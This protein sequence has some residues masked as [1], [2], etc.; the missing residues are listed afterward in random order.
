MK[1][2]KIAAETSAFIHKKTQYSNIIQ[3]LPISPIIDQMEQNLRNAPSP[4][5]TREI[6]G[7]LPKMCYHLPY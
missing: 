2:H 4:N 7:L 6:M 3:K 1:T 5:S